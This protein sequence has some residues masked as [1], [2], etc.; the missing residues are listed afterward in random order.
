MPM[1]RAG[2]INLVTMGVAAMTVIGVV[3]VGVV[4]GKA[5]PPTI[6]E[7]IAGIRTG[8]VAVA[9]LLLSADARAEVLQDAGIEV[10][11]S[12]N[13]ASTTVIPASVE[14]AECYQDFSGPVPHG[15]STVGLVE[16]GDATVSF[17]SSAQLYATPDDAREAIESTAERRRDLCAS[18]TMARVDTA[19]G[20]TLETTSVTEGE[21]EEGV[22]TYEM[23]TV[24]T[25]SD[26]FV[27]RGRTVRFLVGNAVF[28][29][30]YFLN[31]P[32]AD[33]PWGDDAIEAYAERM[34]GYV[35]EKTAVDD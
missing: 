29:M 6:Q 30:G 14:P 27:Q 9:D 13:N 3:V 19:L 23:E 33:A 35:A 28:S 5:P 34:D 24:L 26:G 10:Q 15:G 12:R 20:I 16:G 11:S 22:P 4:V 32:I 21:T 1:S 31:Q 8:P 7:R 18:M 17:E 25:F 2:V